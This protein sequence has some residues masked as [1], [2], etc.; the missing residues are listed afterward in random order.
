MPQGRRSTPVLQELFAA[1][2]VY[3]RSGLTSRYVALSRS[4]QVSVAVGLGV[5]ALWLGLASYA[6]IA[7][8]LETLA[9]GRELARLESI[10]K[11]LRT[12]VEQ[13]Q[14]VPEAGRQAEAVPDLVAE[15]ADA[16]TARDRAH[17]LAQA[18]AGEATELRHELALARDEIRDLRCD[19]ARVET[20]GRAV[21]DHRAAFAGPAG[22]RA[23]DGAEVT[24]AGQLALAD[25][26]CPPN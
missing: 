21:A 17:T 25:P 20:D 16:K 5:L 18:A 3:V 11:T 1:R 15:L 7:K 8:H 4:L 22:R 19:L 2:Q 12:T 24:L 26:A 6:A 23:A 10:T 14:S 9:Q 13:A